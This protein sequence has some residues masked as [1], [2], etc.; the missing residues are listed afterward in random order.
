MTGVG[1]SPALG[2]F[3]A[4]VVL[5][6]SAYRHEL[7]SDIEPFRGLLM[8]LFFIAVGA[9]IDFALIAAQPLLILG[10][11]LALMAVKFGILFGLAR[12]FRLSLD[13]GLL[14]AFALAQGGEFGFVL[15]S[16]AGQQGVLG[17]AVTGLLTAVV[18]I[19]MVLTPLLL[20]VNERLIQPNVGTRASADRPADTVEEANPVIIAGFGEFGNGVGRLLRANGVGTTIL[21]IDSDRVEVLRKLGIKVYYGDATRHDLLEAAGA[22]QAKIIVLALEDQ[23]TEK[24]L[25]LVK[26]IRKHFPHLEIMARAEDRSAAYDLIEAGVEH[27]YRQS[28]DT[29]LRTGVDILSHLGFRAYQSQ[30]TAQRFARYDEEALHEL[31]AMRDDRVAYLNRARERIA[32]MEQYLRSDMDRGSASQE[33]DAAWDTET[34]IA[35]VRQFDQNRPA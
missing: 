27:I 13:Q 34:L 35:D 33:R 24:M 31:A 32:D 1:L 8:G 9:S 22:E 29:S 21:D 14:F 6:G 19:S 23:G 26:T 11:V 2:T 10:L 28:F 18:A 12:L 20:I 4:G 3:L 5:A 16:S 30:R 17:E 25:E 15:L 7:E